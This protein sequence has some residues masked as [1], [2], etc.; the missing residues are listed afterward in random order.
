MLTKSHKAGWICRT[1]MAAASILLCVPAAWAHG[2]H[3]GAFAPHSAYSSRP[4]RPPASAPRPPTRGYPRS[5]TAYPRQ[6][7][8]GQGYA[9]PSY[10]GYTRPPYPGHVPLA[11]GPPGHLGDWLNQHR[12]LPIQEQE[13]V[14]R[15]DPNFRRLSPIDQQRVVQQLYQVNQLP[16]EQRQRRLARAEMIEHLPPQELIRINNSA[17]LWATLPVDRQAMMRRA[18]QDLRAVPLEQRPMV[19]NSA[20][21]QGVFTPEERGI[22][23]DLL[24]VEPYQPAR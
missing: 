6:P 15:S 9:R 20:R 24:R 22:L 12:N 3:S 5:H 7:Y 1:A 18:F 14:L 19:L 8:M 2:Q 10:P 4:A 16:E 23:T 13:R 17:R 21:Y 11:P